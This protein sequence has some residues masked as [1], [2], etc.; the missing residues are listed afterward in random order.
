MQLKQPGVSDEELLKLNGG[1]I[2]D[3]VRV[4]KEKYNVGVTVEERALN[5]S[6]VKKE[7]DAGRIIEMDA[8]NI[9]AETYE[10]KIETGHALAIVGYVTSNDRDS[11]KVPYY[12]IWNP[13]WSSTF[14]IPA[15]N[16]TFRLAGIDYKWMRSWYNWRQNGSVSVDK[17]TAKQSV[18]SMG[19]PN[20]VVEKNLIEPNTLLRGETVYSNINLKNSQDVMQQYVSEFG[21]ETTTRSLLGRDT[22]GYA[23]TTDYAHSTQ[24]SRHGEHITT[25]PANSDVATNFK[26]DVD[27]MNEI[28]EKILK[29]GIGT[30]AS[31]V[32]LTIAVAIPGVNLLVGALSIAG[33]TGGSYSLVTLIKYLKEYLQVETT[34]RINYTMCQNNR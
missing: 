15:D 25:N 16:S 29:S 21:R 9:N 10:E 28:Y 1:S 22:F 8:Y 19:N 2:G 24:R 26:K 32:A 14:Y 4:I 20:S 31:V 18:A 7:I 11:N 13:W 12:E 33:I 27:K 3:S 34:I 23:Q 6:E 30:V 17:F 5:F